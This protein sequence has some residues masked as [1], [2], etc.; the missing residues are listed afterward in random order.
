M[1]AN[2]ASWEV[3]SVLR[4][5]L[6]EDAASWTVRVAGSVSNGTAT[7]CS[8]D[9]D[10]HVICTERVAYQLP[11]D[12]AAR[13]VIAATLHCPVPCK[14]EE[15]RSRVEAGLRQRFGTCVTPRP[16]ALEICGTNQRL[17]ADVVVG[18]MHRCYTGVCPCCGGF[19]FHE[20]VELRSRGDAETRVI[21]Y[22]E[23]RRS[24]IAEHDQQAGARYRPI[25]RILKCVRR[26]FRDS[27]DA[28]LVGLVEQI[29]SCLIEAV[30]GCVPAERFR[31]SGSC[32]W[33]VLRRV[34]PEAMRLVSDP[35]RAANLMDLCGIDPLFGPSKT[36]SRVRLER[37]LGVAWERLCRHDLPLGS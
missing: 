34:I 3:Q 2:R 37:F 16:K 36:W 31:E 18:L 12:A 24:R 23:R 32:H 13:E 14:F 10:L 7:V 22:P 9:V 27:G 8:S 17:N 4:S 20:G 26:S 25:V 33:P 1:K 30:L 29:P 28:E 6:G 19:H 11:E 5:V 21:C 15:D 35:F